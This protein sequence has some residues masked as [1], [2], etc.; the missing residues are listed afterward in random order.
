[1]MGYGSGMGGMGGM[2]FGLLMMVGLIVLVV[3]L[4][5]VMGGGV[6]RGDGSGADRPPPADSD[7]PARRLLH[8]RY[9]RGERSPEE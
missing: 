1:M 8:E 4:V 5:R 3:V 2:F 7:A 9:E 6:R